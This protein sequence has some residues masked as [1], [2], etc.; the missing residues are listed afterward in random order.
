MEVKGENQPVVSSD[1]VVKGNGRGRACVP[2]RSAKICSSDFK[3]NAR[4]KVV[5]MSQDVNLNP[6]IASCDALLLEPTQSGEPVG[7]REKHKND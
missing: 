3:S 6:R 7:E 4:T 1:G 2:A 5:V